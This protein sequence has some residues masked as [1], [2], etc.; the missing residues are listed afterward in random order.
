[1]N[2]KKVIIILITVT[3]ESTNRAIPCSMERTLTKRLSLMVS[4]EINFMPQKN[5]P[6]PNTVLW[7]RK[8]EI[9]VKLFLTLKRTKNLVNWIW[10]WILRV[11][12]SSVRQLVSTPNKA[13]TKIKSS[14]SMVF[15]VTLSFIPKIEREWRTLE[16]SN[17][18]DKPSLLLIWP[19]PKIWGL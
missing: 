10:V 15:R 8:V 4:K 3:T 1:M 14:N 17:H 12:W 5:L 18:N 11:K 13:P 2:S 16:V 6:T 9:F 19:G 7:E